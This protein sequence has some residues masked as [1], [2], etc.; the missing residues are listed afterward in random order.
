MTLLP[1]VIVTRPDA[2]GRML[3][4]ELA[5]R[6]FESLWLP[7]FEIGPA[8]DE[9]AARDALARLAEFDLAVFVSPAA[10][11]ATAALL[12]GAWPA[13]T[14][15]GAVGAAT[16]RAVAQSI[17]GALSAA[18]IAPGDADEAD[19][20]SEALWD[21]LMRSALRLQRVLLLRAEGGR[22]WLAERLA[23]AGARVTAVAVYSRRVRSAGEDEIATLRRWKDAGRQPAMVVTSSEA[24]DVL[25]RQIERAGALEW[26]HA[27]LAL[28]TH[29]RI[30]ERLRAAGFARVALAAARADAIVDAINAQVESR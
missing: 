17:P 29:A 12:A 5:A 21:A 26:L 2:G 7:A 13:R 1:P 10:V 24:V 15:I 25:V 27:G 14:A 11:R 4:D 30:A 3:A 22:M 6:G 19:A 16:A 9:R 8:P 23:E 18:V 28:A 20:G